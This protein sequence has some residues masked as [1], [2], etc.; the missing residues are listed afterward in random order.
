MHSNSSNDNY[1]YR[2][3]QTPWSLWLEIFR[4]N[5]APLFWWL[6]FFSFVMAYAPWPH[7]LPR[8]LLA[9]TWALAGAIGI[10]LMLF[11]SLL[12]YSR[13]VWTLGWISLGVL[14]SFLLPV[15]ILLGTALIAIIFG[16]I[17]KKLIILNV[18]SFCFLGV[19]VTGFVY[20]VMI[21][22]VSANALELGYVEREHR[23]AALIKIMKGFADEKLKI[24]VPGD[25]ID[26]HYGSIA[27]NIAR[28]G[29]ELIIF[30]VKTTAEAAKADF[31]LFSSALST[32]D[33]I[34]EGWAPAIKLQPLSSEI[35]VPLTFWQWRLNL[36]QAASL[37]VT[38]PAARN[39]AWILYGRLPP[40]G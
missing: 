7:R 2:T 31:L 14:L 22:F 17:A 24:G 10:E 1:A 25:L 9:P 18:A 21:G 11:L 8:Y 3:I 15:K 30:S 19:W 16:I 28:A 6:T 29:G 23:Q 5:T 39:D 34:P 33:N 40:T 26:E 13:R 38:R 20:F 27:G 12:D 32:L 4:Q 37:G 36:W 35:P